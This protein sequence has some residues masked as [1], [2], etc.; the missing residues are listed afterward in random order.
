MEISGKNKNQ[1]IWLKNNYKFRY[2]V[3]SGMYE[4]RKLHKSKPKLGSTWEEYGDRFKNDIMLEMDFSDNKISGDLL[5]VYVESTYISPDYDPILEYFENLNKPESKTS[6][7]DELVKTIKCDNPKFFEL[8]F[9]KFLV[10]TVACLLEPDAVNDTCLVF[11][12]PQGAGKSRWM[13][14]LLPQRFRSRLLK[15]GNI[16]PNHKDAKIS[17]AQ[18]WFIHL[19]ELETLKG[20]SLS[21]VKSFITQQRISERK[22]YGRYSSHFVR[23]ASFIGSVNDPKFLTDITG[24]R[25]WL[26]FE[27]NSIDYQHN[28]DIDGVW[29]EAYQLYCDGFAHWFDHDE[30]KELNEINDN[31]REMSSEEELL[32]KL[33]EF[34][35]IED[36]SGNWYSSTEIKMEIIRMHGHI[37]QQLN[38]NVLGRSLTRYCTLR[39]KS[40]VM[41]YYVRLKDSG[42]AE[43]GDDDSELPF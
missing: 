11:R 35:E 36:G 2:N 9:K 26:V 30:I 25:R 22:S 23:R 12:S 32:L 34:P 6:K 19:D 7:I 28:I 29:A 18:Y 5:T 20:K 37:G 38:N 8:A 3:V 24:N 1:Y 13:R 10:S 27:I 33:F 15:E 17:L 14:K 43:G 21:D 39:K 31:F 40:G 4:F 16:D 42:V 41:K